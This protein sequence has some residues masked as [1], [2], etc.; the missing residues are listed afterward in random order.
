MP[1]LGWDTFWRDHKEILYQ[2]LLTLWHHRMWQIGLIFCLLFSFVHVHGQVPDMYGSYSYR[3]WSYKKGLP[4]KKRSNLHEG[5][6]MSDMLHSYGIRR[7]ISWPS[8]NLF[9]CTNKLCSCFNLLI[10]QIPKVHIESWKLWK[11]ALAIYELVLCKTA[12]FLKY[13]MQF[14]FPCIVIVLLPFYFQYYICWLTL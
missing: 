7:S 3:K 6:P 14:S 9:T 11:C 12:I 4:L 2:P 5:H 13:C 1:Q 8:K 10:D